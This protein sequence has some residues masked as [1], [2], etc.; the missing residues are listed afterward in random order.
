MDDC[1]DIITF[2][3]PFIISII[4]NI[5]FIVFC[6]HI[7]QSEDLYLKAVKRVWNINPIY[8]IDIIKKKGYEDIYLIDHSNEGEICDCTH[9]G[10][11]EKSFNG[12]CNEYKLDEGCIEYNKTKAASSINGLNLY[13]SYYESDYLTLFSRI[14]DN[15]ED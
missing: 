3:A 13:V 2:F 7:Y 5:V 9:V 4:I 6:F 12:K 14:D 15:N 8:D 10:E 1:K 11:F